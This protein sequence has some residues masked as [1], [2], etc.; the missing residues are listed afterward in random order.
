[1]NPIDR[2]LSVMPSAV[3]KLCYSAKVGVLLL[4]E[5]QFAQKDIPFS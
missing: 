5:I 1:M 4:H 3:Q 2:S